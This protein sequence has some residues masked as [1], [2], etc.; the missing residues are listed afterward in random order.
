MAA[1]A[2]SRPDARDIARMVSLPQMFRHL[3]WR[4][5]HR[6]RVDCGLCK[7]SSTGTV[8]YREHIWH[9]HRCHAGGDVYAL[10][11]QFQHCDFRAALAYV[12]DMA[13]IKLHDSHN[14]ADACRKIAERQRQ[15]DRIDTA[16]ETLAQMERRHRLECRNRIHAAER[17]LAALSKVSAWSERDWLIAST[18]HDSLRHD[19]AE[20][21]LLS[22]GAI[23]V[24]AEYV[25]KPE[26][27]KQM[28]GSLHVAGSVRTDSGHWR[29]VVA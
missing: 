16:A 11:M 17:K 14:S 2:S 29:E 19:L 3:G 24:R 1:A 7:G 26:Q 10:V 23:P 28:V 13:G 27:R 6:N 15:R 20:Y 18:L 22:F 9:C 5:R 4:I 25:L 8:A 21:T 12:A